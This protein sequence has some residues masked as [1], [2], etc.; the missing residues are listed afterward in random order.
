[1]SYQY[2]CALSGVSA[3]GTEIE[4]EDLEDLPIGW[5]RVEIQRRVPN[6]KWVLIQQT[7]MMA[8]E[9][10]LQ[11]IPEEVRE[12]QRP[13]IALQVEAQFKLIENDTPPFFVDVKD[14]VYFSDSKD[15]NDAFNEIREQLGLDAVPSFEE[16]RSGAEN[17]E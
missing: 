3:P 10:V 7:K 8:I 6:P 15:V 13:F 16:L 5:T 2:T 1:M 11:Q 9:T 17:A 12:E 4:D 14:V